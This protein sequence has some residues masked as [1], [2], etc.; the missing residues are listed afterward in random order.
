MRDQLDVAVAGQTYEMYHL[1]VDSPLWQR[2]FNAG[3]RRQRLLWVSTGTEDPEASDVFDFDTV[4]W[5]TPTNRSILLMRQ[6]AWDGEES[7]G[8]AVRADP[9]GIRVRHRYGKGSGAQAGSA[10]AHG[11]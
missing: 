4:K 1:L 2:I 6:E 5:P 3:A 9:E 10:P 8:G 7:E 11:S